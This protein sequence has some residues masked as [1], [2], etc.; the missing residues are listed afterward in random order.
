MKKNILDDNIKGEDGNNKV[1]SDIDR[2]RRSKRD[3]DQA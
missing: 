1:N 2:E 3:N